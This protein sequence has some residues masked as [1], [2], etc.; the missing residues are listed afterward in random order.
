MYSDGAHVNNL[1][2][3]LYDAAGIA[4]V[5]GTS[6]MLRWMVAA[7]AHA[8]AIIRRGDLQPADQAMG[9]GPFTVHHG[10][11]VSFRVA[12]SGIFTGIR[13]MYV[14]D[15][16]LQHGLLHIESGDIVVDLG[17]NV[18]NFCNLA[19]AH[20]AARVVAV[21]PSLPLND[22]MWRSIKLNPG[23]AER[24]T[25]IRAFVGASSS[26]K[27]SIDAD[28]AYDDAQWLTEAEL[29]A[30]TKLERIDFLKCDIEGGEF[31]LLN[32][33]SRVLGMVR[34]IAVEI[35]SFA[36]NVDAFVGMLRDAG[37]TILHE[38]RDPDGTRT[39]LARR[40]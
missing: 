26:L 5:L 31:S 35:H 8:Q 13:E 18:G 3:L 24:L 36:G 6:A 23:F 22:S 34:K 19:L 1:G 15:V 4:R 7:I 10:R 38:Q 33:T 17:S 2:K 16:Y 21:E 39:V 14:R 40:S 30:A 27:E 32:P 11:N 37:F 9:Q 20:G 29:L 25:L 12:G 28:P